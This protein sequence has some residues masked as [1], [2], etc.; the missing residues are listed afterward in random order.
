MW[1]RT[2]LSNLDLYLPTVG[3]DIEKLNAY[4]AT[5]LEQLA[6][7]GEVTHDMLTNLLKGYKA[8]KD[9]KFVEYIKKK[10]D[11][12]EDGNNMT[13]E[14]LMELAVNKFKS[15]KQKGTW[16]APSPEEEKILALEAKIQKLERQAKKP[17]KK[18]PPPKKNA[19][20]KNQPKGK[21]SLKKPDWMLKPPTDNEKGKSKTVEKKEYWWCPNHK[22]W[23][24]HKPSDC[25]GVGANR[26]SANRDDSK[27]LKLSKAL[28][29][30]AEDGSDEE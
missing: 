13:P 19:K 2:Q 10:E 20:V 16:N 3:N 1:I 18:D 29:A 21:Q 7:R 4:A 5:L 14:V 12:Y 22:C 30:V 23:C 24:R 26:D 15:M 8:A 25:K 9:K 6:A 27:K 11:D 28:A 17:I